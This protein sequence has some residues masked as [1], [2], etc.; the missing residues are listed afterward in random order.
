MYAA[1]LNLPHEPR[2][3]GDGSKYT[4]GFFDLDPYPPTGQMLYDV[5]EWLKSDGWITY[6]SLPFDRYDIDA[7]VLIRYLAEQDLGPYLRFSK[8]LNYYAFVDDWDEIVEGFERHAAAGDID[9]VLAWATG[10]AAMASEYSDSMAVVAYPLTDPLGRGIVNGVEYSGVPNVW[11]HTDYERYERQMRVFKEVCDFQKIGAVYYDAG[12]AVIAD[13]RKSAE[14]LS[15]ELVERQIEPLESDDADELE[16]YLTSFFDSVR[17]LLINEEIDAFLLTTD[18][19]KSDEQLDR[20]VSA[21]NGL[22]V[23]IFVQFGDSFVERGALM[24]VQLLDSLSVGHFVANTIGKILNG[25]KPE[26]LNQYYPSMPYL[27]LNIEA[28]RELGI[29]VPFEMLMSSE[30][31]SGGKK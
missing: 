10:P 3:K 7:Q 22:K 30:K 19:I 13:Y 8:E 5:I 6:D 9:I 17:D 2:T 24:T 23:P 15:V 18:M 4:I 21:C 16:A 26:E 1:E 27:V 29:K 28:A 11:A 12:V 20:L 31:I 14:N 25:A